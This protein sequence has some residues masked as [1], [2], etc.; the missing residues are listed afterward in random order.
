MFILVLL[1]AFPRFLPEEPVGGYT[2]VQKTWQAWTLVDFGPSQFGREVF[3]RV[4]CR[5]LENRGKRVL[6]LSRSLH[7]V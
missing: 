6:S 1:R 4:D 7:P 3:A 2:E 5:R